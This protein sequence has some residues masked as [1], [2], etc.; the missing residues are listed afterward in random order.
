MLE[1]QKALTKQVEDLERCASFSGVERHQV[2]VVNI[3]ESPRRSLADGNE[4]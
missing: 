2:L 1:R 3:L 4:P